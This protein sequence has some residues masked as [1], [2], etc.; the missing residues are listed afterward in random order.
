MMVLATSSVSFVAANGISSLKS[1][2]NIDSSHNTPPPQ[3]KNK[4]KK[5]MTIDAENISGK[6]KKKRRNIEAEIEK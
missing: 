6:I 1:I 4:I 5:V 2:M 3:K